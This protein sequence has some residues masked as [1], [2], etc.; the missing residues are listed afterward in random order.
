LSNGFSATNLPGAPCSLTLAGPIA[1]ALAN[2]VITNNIPS[3]ASLVLGSATAPSTFGMNGITFQGTGMTIINDKFTGLGDLTVQGGATVQLNNANNDFN[4]TVSVVNVGSKLLVNGAKTVSQDVNIGAS[5][6]LGGTG[7]IAGNINN[8][9]TIAPG[10]NGV[11]TL[12]TMNDVF[13]EFNSHLAIDL[14]GGMADKLV[15]GGNLDLSNTEFLDISGSRSGLSYVIATYTGTLTGKFNN[16]TAGYTVNYGTGNNSQI[17]LTAALTGVKGDFNNNGR[18]DAA[19]YVLWRNNLGT[20]NA[21][22]NDNGLGTPITQ[23]H[24]SLWRSAFNSPNGGSGSFST[25]EV[26]EPTSAILLLAGIGC[27]AL[28]AGR[29]RIAN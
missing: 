12:T 26:P 1:T 14:A 3:G 2:R 17:T 25:G 5:G 16:I 18:V 27:F 24:Y 13:M 21:L 11:G 29:R 20:N 4:G 15:V 8:L 7:S 22:L 10:V 28:A 6:T 9:G 19:D 23:S